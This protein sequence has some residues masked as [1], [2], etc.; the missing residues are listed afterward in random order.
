M[1]IED[2][3]RALKPEIS[4]ALPDILPAERFTRMDYRH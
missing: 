3:I 4:K 1:N 2:L